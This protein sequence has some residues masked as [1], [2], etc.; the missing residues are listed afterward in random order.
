MNIVRNDE[1]WGGERRADGPWPLPYLP[2]KL[3]VV[4]DF[5]LSIRF[6][7]NALFLQIWA[8]V[9][10]AVSKS[11]NTFECILFVYRTH[12]YSWILIWKEGDIFHRYLQ[13]HRL[14]AKRFQ[15]AKFT[16]Q[17]LKLHISAF[18]KHFLPVLFFF[19][20]AD[21]EYVIAFAYL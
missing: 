2:K 4:L 15:T 10:C 7:D 11:K 16:F 12:R 1:T 5:N 9:T 13:G 14:L 20:H 18:V 6:W 17:C 3:Y 21:R 8:F 19:F